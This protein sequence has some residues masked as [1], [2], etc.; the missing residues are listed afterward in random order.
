MCYTFIAQ[1]RSTNL[2][3]LKME[4]STT[5]QLQ[6]HD[7]SRGTRKVGPGEGPSVDL[8]GMGVR[9]M[10]YAEET[11]AGFSVVEH[12][13][14][15]RALGGPLH[16]HTRED[17]YSFVLE[18]KM[19]AILGDDVVYAE[20]GDLV[21]KPREQWHTFWNAGDEPT[22]LLEI[23]SPGGFEHY[24]EDL[25]A[26][27]ASGGPPDMPAMTEKYGIHFDLSSIDRICA[28]HGVTHPMQGLIPPGA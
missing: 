23:I 28:E 12:P 5:L 18:G 17:E 3:E 9:F 1:H 15:P 16:M 20:A 13:L 19:G 22:R 24:F 10:A 7:A 27:L 6:R 2:K 26:M 25:A 4:A 11:G 21:F 14:E 8:G